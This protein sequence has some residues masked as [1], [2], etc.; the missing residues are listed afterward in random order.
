M[1]TI[2]VW[3]GIGA[4]VGLAAGVGTEQLS[5]GRLAHKRA[6]ASTWQQQFDATFPKDAD[7]QVHGDVDAWMRD[8]PAPTGTKLPERGSSEL[9]GPSRHFGGFTTGAVV[10]T[11]AGAEF[12]SSMADWMDNMSGD[13]DK[14]SGQKG[15]A[16]LGGMAAGV[17]VGRL[18][19]K[20][21]SG[22]H[23]GS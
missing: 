12:Y 8:H 7:G 23:D 21:L 10:G 6:D 1:N 4:A 13:Y 14:V 20:L 19:S 18:G 5:Y 15:T 11:A 16:F 17:L 22:H 2:A 3:A 9:Q